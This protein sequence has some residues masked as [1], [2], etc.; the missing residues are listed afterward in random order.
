MFA[1]SSIFA[2][3]QV[4]IVIDWIRKEH[5]F[6]PDTVKSFSALE[7]DVRYIVVVDQMEHVVK[8]KEFFVLGFTEVAVP[9]AASRKDLG[10]HYDAFKLTIVVFSYDSELLHFC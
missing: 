5:P 2:N 4:V 7:L 8:F 6:S 10:F 9:S 1:V 3:L